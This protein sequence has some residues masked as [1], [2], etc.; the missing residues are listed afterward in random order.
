M[1]VW[2]IR[3]GESES[4]AGLPTNGPG[5]SPLTGLGREQAGRVAAAF[6]GPPDLIVASSFVRARET[7]RPTRERFPDVPYEEWPVQ[8]FT[9]LGSLHG[10]STTAEERRP[11]VEEYWTRCDPAYSNG[12]GESFQDLITRGREFVDRLAARP[13]QGLVAVFTHGIFM[14]ALL[15]SLQLGVSAPDHADMESFR[16]FMI[17]SATPN[18]T[19]AELRLAGGHGAGVVIGSTVHL[20]APS[21]RPA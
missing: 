3:H 16:T 10:P 8:E 18:G 1:R 5:A 13:E 6:D 15:W 9:Y 7:A 21:G 14:R 19:I 20:T 12:G 4:N 2:L 17:N 11:H